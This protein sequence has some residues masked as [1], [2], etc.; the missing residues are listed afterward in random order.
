MEQSTTREMALDLCAR[1][2][3]IVGSVIPVPQ[4][5]S[6]PTCNQAGS[7][8]YPL[9]SSEAG[10]G[11]DSS[12]ELQRMTLGPSGAAMLR[13]RKE[14]P[15]TNATPSPIQV[16]VTSSRMQSFF[17]AAMERF[18]KEQQQTPSNMPAAARETA[19]P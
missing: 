14:A 18:L 7:S 17:A 13:S 6:N 9:T 10:S 12:V 19:D 5:T 16:Q 2:A 3:T 11:S 8:Q 4:E 1:L 15:E